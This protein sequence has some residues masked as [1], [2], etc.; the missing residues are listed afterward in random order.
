MYSN[1]EWKKDGS[2]ELLP[3]DE[4]AID[5]LHNQEIAAGLLILIYITKVKVENTNEFT[6]TLVTAFSQL[7]TEL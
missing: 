3:G 5:S 1:R 6:S 4:P 2:S 7:N